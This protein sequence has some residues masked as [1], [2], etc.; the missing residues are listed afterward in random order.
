[1]VLPADVALVP[2]QIFPLDVKAA[3]I[4]DGPLKRAFNAVSDILMSEGIS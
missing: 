3:M 4:F 2:A 1:M